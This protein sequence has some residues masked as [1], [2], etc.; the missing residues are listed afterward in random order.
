MQKVMSRRERI[1]LY[2]TIAV[3]A[4]SV[5]F[6]VF[7]APLLARMQTLDRDIALTGEKINKYSRLLAQKDSLRSRYNDLISQM[8]TPEGQKKD[9]LVNA[10]RG[11]ENIAR[12]AQIRI[13]DIR[14]QASGSQGSSKEVLIELKSAGSMEGFLKFIY[15]VQSSLLLLRVKKFE[16]S[17]KGKAGNLEAVM[18]IAASTLLD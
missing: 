2:V 8:G 14:P 5:V 6:K 4:L 17:A 16:L 13:V 1:I 12:S 11:L 15:D 7:F 9:T 10:L 18:T 3:V